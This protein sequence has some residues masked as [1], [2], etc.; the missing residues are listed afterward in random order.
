MSVKLLLKMSVS[1][2]ALLYLWQKISVWF[3][4]FVAENVCLVY[5]LLKM[6]IWFIYGVKCLLS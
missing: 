2:L 5:P 1:L 3:I 4:I 6:S